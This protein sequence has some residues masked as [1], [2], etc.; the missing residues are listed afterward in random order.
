MIPSGPGLGV[1]ICRDLLGLSGTCSCPF[2][3]LVESLGRLFALCN[4]AERRVARRADLGCLSESDP[5]VVTS[6]EERVT[7]AGVDR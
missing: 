4:L 1:R 6:A 3:V 2:V 5:D 7:R